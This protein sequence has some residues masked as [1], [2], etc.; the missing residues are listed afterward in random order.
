[1][2]NPE[3]S[4]SRAEI[5]KAVNSVDNGPAGG[6]SLNDYMKEFDIKPLDLEGK[7]VLDLGAA[8]GLRVADEL[9]ARAITA[10]VV[11]F[12][13]IFADPTFRSQARLMS[14]PEAASLAV[15]GMGETLPFQDGSFD[16]VLA[17]QVYQYLD[18]PKRESDFLKELVRVLAPNGQ[19]YVGPFFIE[20]EFDTLKSIAM[21]QMVGESASVSWREPEWRKTDKHAWV[22]R[23]TKAEK[24]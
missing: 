10:D 16:T 19:A 22:M 23:V 6:R 13:P 4:Y 5:N 12:S 17:L 14:S 18:T 3:K 15:A 8:V 7:R 24:K 20:Q 21:K 9:K 11:S 2:E 1:M